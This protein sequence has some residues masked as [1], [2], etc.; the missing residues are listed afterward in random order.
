MTTAFYIVDKL[1]LAEKGHLINFERQRD[2]GVKLSFFFKMKNC[3][4]ISYFDYGRII[5]SSVASLA[6]T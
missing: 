2:N 4:R 5:Y 6:N 1:I 3:P